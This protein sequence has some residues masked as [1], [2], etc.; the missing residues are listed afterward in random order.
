MSLDYLLDAANWS[1]TSPDGF[2]QRI[3]EHLGYTFLALAIAAVI[4]FP[5]GLL[6]GHTGRGALIAINLGNA[7]RA[8]PTLGVLMLALGLVG[9]GLVPVTI[10]LV[11]LAVPPILATTYAGIQSVADETVDAA[12]GV[13]MTEAQIAWRVEVPIALPII[14]GGLR[15]ASLQ[16]VSTATIAAYVGL[17]GLGRYLF[18]G[19]AT[20]QYDMVVAGAIV[21]AVL[22]V[23]I[24]LALAGTQR[25]LVSPGVDGREA[26][27]RP[28]TLRPEPAGQPAGAG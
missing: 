17:G 9:I 24:D 5:I 2:P 22:A 3:L 7:G 23:A 27:D 13:G 12:R 8:L 10:A 15:N 28:T 1:L 20:L 18:D 16:V 25:L 19:L 21:L 26:G 14:I 4:A 11:V 6:I